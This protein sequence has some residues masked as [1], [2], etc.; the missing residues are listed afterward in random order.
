MNKIEKSGIRK[1]I[2][3]IKFERNKINGKIERCL[4]Y[5]RLKF[6]LTTGMSADSE[7]AKDQRNRL[8]RRRFHSC[9]QLLDRDENF[10]IFIRKT[11][12]I[13]K[14]KRRF[15]KKEEENRTSALSNFF[16]RT[17]RGLFA[18]LP[19]II[20]FSFTFPSITLFPSCGQVRLNG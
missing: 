2:Q 17:W 7:E 3:R 12:S 11:S 18:Q 1:K 9:N 20:H 6:Y 10:L 5:S 16:E 19:R 14:T 4:I 13:K 15:A 8:S